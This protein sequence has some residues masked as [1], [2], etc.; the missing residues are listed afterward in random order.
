MHVWETV[1]GL[2][3][4]GWCSSPDSPLAQ[5]GAKRSAVYGGEAYLVSDCAQARDRGAGRG[6]EGRRTSGPTLQGA[7]LNYKLE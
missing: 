3:R 1:A 5:R 6:M 4:R 7:A 2:T